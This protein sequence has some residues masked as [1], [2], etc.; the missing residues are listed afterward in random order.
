VGKTYRRTKLPRERK[1][2]RLKAGDKGTGREQIDHGRYFRCWHCGFICDIER[3]ELSEGRNGSS[4]SNYYS[5]ALGAMP[6]SGDKSAML[7]LKMAQRTFILPK[8]DSSGDAVTVYDHWVMDMSGCP[9]CG[10]RAW[11]K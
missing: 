2:I 1:T 10:C 3:D 9:L 4:V 7:V 8:A 5:N 6:G 11:K